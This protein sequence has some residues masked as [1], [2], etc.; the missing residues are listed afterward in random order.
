MNSM[1]RFTSNT[2][3]Y[4]LYSYSFMWK[5]SS[6]VNRGQ[7][8]PYGDLQQGESGTLASCRSI[9]HVALLLLSTSIEQVEV[10]TFYSLRCH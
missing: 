7:P 3:Y 5:S 4:V 6:K 10:L 9:L 1:V 2:N 8:N